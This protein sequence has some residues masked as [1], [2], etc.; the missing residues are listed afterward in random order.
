MKAREGKGLCTT[1]IYLTLLQNG[2]ELKG[3]GTP[4]PNAA[5]ATTYATAT[6]DLGGGGA[7]VNGTRYNHSNGG[8]AV[9][10]NGNGSIVGVGGAIQS[11][12]QNILEDTG[13]HELRTWPLLG[14]HKWYVNS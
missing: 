4:P 7:V 3:S 12:T 2:L 5:T 1:E 13:K 14:G 10:S 11:S 8:A 6:F 9:V